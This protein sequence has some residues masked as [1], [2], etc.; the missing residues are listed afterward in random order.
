MTVLLANNVT[1]SLASPI[2]AAATS[3]TVVSGSRFPVLTAGQYFY[4]TII[5]STGTI[6]IVKVTVRSGNTMNIVR[7][8]DGT[9]AQAFLA[10]SRVEM[11]TNVLSITDAIDDRIAPVAARVTTVEGEIDALQAADVS[12]DARLDVAEAE[13]DVLQAFDTTVSSSAGSNSV[14][15]LQAGTGATS[16]TVQAKLRET[17]SVKDFGAVGNGTAD[18]TAAIQAAINTGKNVVGQLGDIY[19][20][21]S[22]VN[23]PATGIYWQTL[24]LSWATIKPDGSHNAITFNGV[25]FALRNARFDAA[26]CTGRVLYAPNIIK[27]FIIEDVV[28]QSPQ[29]D[30]VVIVDAYTGRFNRLSVLNA[31]ARSFYAYSNTLGTPINSIWVENSNFDGSSFTGNVVTF[32]GVAGC[33][34]KNTSFQG[35]ASTSTDLAIQGTAN[36]GANGVTIEGC[37]WETGASVDGASIAVNGTASADAANI[38]I[39]NCYFQT[40]KV[41]VSL[42]AYTDKSISVTNSTFVSVTPWSYS[43]WLATLGDAPRLFNI[44]GDKSL[45]A[46][47][48]RASIGLRDVFYGSGTPESAV[49]ADVGSLYMRTDTGGTSLYVK[50]FNNGTNTGWIPQAGWSSVPVATGAAGIAGQ[51]AYDSTH[52]YV[53]VATNTWRRVAISTW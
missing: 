18:D 44:G 28:I 37:Y 9:N 22:T 48:S 23:F 51:M 34:I 11:R 45:V 1:S 38:Y 17:V 13:I 12:L 26:S 2:T 47:T 29:G 43:S 4:A 33:F 7:A 53:C 41:D 6:E 35:N 24:D 5:A 36:A 19:R 40:S 31:A 50:E 42:G 25:Q 20:T 52:F 49:I 15:F 16:R 14:G 21:T 3:M 8:Q 46:A 32:E 27:E 30:A 39:N 10:G